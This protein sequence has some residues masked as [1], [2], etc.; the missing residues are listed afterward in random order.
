[1][2]LHNCS[3]TLFLI[4]SFCIS[5]CQGARGLAGERGRAGPAGP[6]GARGADGN[7][8]PAGPAVSTGPLN[9]LY[10]TLETGI[11]I[12]PIQNALCD[13][14]CVSNPFKKIIK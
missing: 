1:M 10:C 6:A 14:V 4:I 7:V 8:G 12:I 5:S 11:I 13:F 9:H 2:Q 3:W